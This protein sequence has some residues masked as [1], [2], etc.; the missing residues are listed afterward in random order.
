MGVISQ[1]SPS[2]RCTCLIFTTAVLT[3]I[4]M[5]A[6]P[7]HTA[8]ETMPEMVQKQEAETMINQAVLTW[9]HFI[10]NPD[11]SG[12][13]A[14]LKDVQGVLIFPKLFKGAF[15]FGA[16][17]GSGVLLVRDKKTGNWSEPAFYEMSSGSFGFQAGM[18]TSEAI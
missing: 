1:R 6:I 16:E 14:H 9:Q 17:G 18:E 4:M 10:L 13:R 15:V 2:Y 8:A 3:G 11:S 12:F 7:R 5:I